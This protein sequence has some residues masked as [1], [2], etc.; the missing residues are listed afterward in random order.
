[1]EA[2]APPT[3]VAELLSLH[4]LDRYAAAFDEHGWDS[5]KRLLAK[6]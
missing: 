3:T 2:G 1:M 6:E 4:E 5:L